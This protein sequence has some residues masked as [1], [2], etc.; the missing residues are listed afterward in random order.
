MTD[1]IEHLKKT[2]LAL[3]YKLL[4]PEIRGDKAALERLLAPNMCEIGRSGKY[5]ERALI[6]KDLVADPSME[7][8]MTIEDFNLQLLSDNVCLVTYKIIENKSL[9]SSIWQE[10]EQGQWQMLFH[11][12]TP[13]D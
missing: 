11:Q 6:I 12:G 3:E 9:R 10:L 1:K 7:E 2:I 5:Y 13:T 8:E 4:N